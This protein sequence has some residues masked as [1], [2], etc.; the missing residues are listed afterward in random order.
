MRLQQPIDRS[1]GDKVLSLV[2][3]AHRQLS[4]RQLWQFQR[5]VDDLAAD[6]IGNPI[7]DDA[8]FRGV[9]RT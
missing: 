8:G 9:L 4:R 7:P 1:L 2:G 6:I 5:Q 3:E